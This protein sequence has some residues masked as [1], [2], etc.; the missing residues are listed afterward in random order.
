MFHWCIHKAILGPSVQID[1]LSNY[2]FIPLVH[3]V[4]LQVGWRM[5]ACAVYHDL[6]DP[7]DKRIFIVLN[8]HH[9]SISLICNQIWEDAGVKML[10]DI[11]H[12]LRGS[13]T[14]K[15]H[16]ISLTTGSLLYLN[17]SCMKPV[18]VLTLS[19]IPAYLIFLDEINWKTSWE[20]KILLAVKLFSCMLSPTW[21]A[22]AEIHFKSA[23]LSVQFSMQLVVIHRFIGAC[24]K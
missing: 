19:C 24:S 15:G 2:S 7:R 11:G 3:G 21:I 8:E 16:H 1:L 13:D 20:N 22:N 23:P 4:L 5:E 9:K 12:L 14:L 6:I 18:C 17:F 10:E